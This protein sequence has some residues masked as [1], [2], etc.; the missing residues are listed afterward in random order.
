M[1]K[2]SYRVRDPD[3]HDNVKTVEAQDPEHAAELV[4]EEWHPHWDHPPT[5]ALKVVCPDGEVKVVDVE[6]EAIP[7][8]NGRVRS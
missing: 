6:V 1:T 3:D 8:F 4:A 5:M 2:Q 7:T